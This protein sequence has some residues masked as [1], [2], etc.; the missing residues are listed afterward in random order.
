M[1]SFNLQQRLAKL[2]SGQIGNVAEVSD[3]LVSTPT[4]DGWRVAAG[5]GTLVSGTATIATGLDTVRSFTATVN[6]TTSPAT[7]TGEV[8]TIYVGTI[9]TGSVVVT[10]AFNAFVT[11]AATI[12][13]SGTS[14]FNWLAFG[15]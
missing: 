10:G 4:T 3:D 9:T 12:S 5:T 7:G 13:A 6:R 8:T 11:G 1:P 15:T 14:T 2:N